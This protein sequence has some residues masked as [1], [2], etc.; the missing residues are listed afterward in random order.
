MRRSRHLAKLLG[1][2]VVNVVFAGVGFGQTAT[3]A[4]ATRPA[5]RVQVQPSATQPIIQTGKMPTHEQFVAIAKKGDID[6]LFL[7]DSITD[8][9]RAG[10]PRNPTDTNHSGRAVW[11]KYFAPLKAANFGIG[12][13]RTQNVL[14][15][16]QN[17]ELD[18]FHAKCIVLLL[19]TNNVTA[20]RAIRN[21][22][23][24]VEAGMKLVIEEIRKRQPQAKLILM[25]IFPRGRREDDPYRAPIKEINSELAKYDDGKN[26]FYMD[27]GDKFLAA[28]GSIPVDLRMVTPGPWPAR[29]TPGGK[30]NEPTLPTEPVMEVMSKVPGPRMIVSPD[31]ATAA[32][33]VGVRKGLSARPRRAVE[34]EPL[35][36][37]TKR[38][39]L[40]ERIDGGMVGISIKNLST[41]GRV[42]A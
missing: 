36:A 23:A 27:I 8:N 33:A 7:G 17:G 42:E 24:D 29:L 26:I 19:G 3:E 28:D 10:P 38:V 31:W 18:G 2:I 16:L 25:G 32:A 12:A 11:S 37:S 13:D 1:M 34:S 39:A 35:A 9:W 5:R 14:W 40:M 30:F 15:R 41:R 4:P 22:N 21:T 20:G 6:L